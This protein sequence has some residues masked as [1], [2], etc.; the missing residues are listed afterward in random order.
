MRVEALKL[1]AE[2]EASEEAAR[3]EAEKETVSLKLK[4]EEADRVRIEAEAFALKLKAE[5]EAHALK[6]KARK[7]ERSRIETEANDLR[8]TAEKEE[9]NVKAN[10]IAFSSNEKVR[11]MFDSFVS[12]SD[13]QSS[14]IQGS[15]IIDDETK[16]ANKE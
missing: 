8:S 7:V 3:I 4:A 10:S 13:K 5:K 15:V 11:Q 16:R 1:K 12:F 14:I 2:Q 9:A 6:L